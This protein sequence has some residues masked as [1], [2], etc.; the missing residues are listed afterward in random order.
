[1]EG[2]LGRLFITKTWL[3][4]DPNTTI[5]LDVQSFLGTKTITATGLKKQR[6]Y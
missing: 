5:T 2:E 4:D 3:P 6:L 1:M